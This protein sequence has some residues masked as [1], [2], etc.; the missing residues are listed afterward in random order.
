MRGELSVVAAQRD[1]ALGQA[2]E[3]K[4]KAVL[5]DENWHATKTKLARVTQEK[6]KLERDQ[7]ATLSL[8]SSLDK[9]VSSS[10]TDFYKRK[11]NELNHKVQGLN[12]IIAEKTRQLDDLRRQVERN[13]TSQEPSRKRTFTK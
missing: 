5:L 1:E 7:R 3:A 2:E 6:V 13:M 4:R 9:H 12:A 8:A 11:V 10:D